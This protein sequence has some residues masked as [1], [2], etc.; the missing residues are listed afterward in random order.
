MKNDKEDKAKLF[1]FEF[2][3]EEI[4][5]IKA[6]LQYYWFNDDFGY[7]LWGTMPGATFGGSDRYYTQRVD[8]IYEKL[9]KASKVKPDYGWWGGIER[10]AKLCN[11]EYKKAKKEG[12]EAEKRMYQ[13]YMI[14]QMEKLIEVSKKTGNYEWEK[15]IEGAEQLEVKEPDEDKK[16]T[17]I[18][19]R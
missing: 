7:A 15:M 8:V 3:K 5:I 4:A 6:G 14:N 10:L 9:K 19:R 17:K 12:E 13:D 1:T 18:S 11:K 16:F 2:T